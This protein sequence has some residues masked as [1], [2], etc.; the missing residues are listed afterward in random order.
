MIPSKLIIDVF[1]LIRGLSDKML[2]MGHNS[3]HWKS[4]WLFSMSGY[5]HAIKMFFRI[6][7]LLIS[8]LLPSISWRLKC[9]FAC[10]ISVHLM[11]ITG[12]IHWL[13]LEVPLSFFLCNNTLMKDPVYL[14]H[15][16]YHKYFFILSV[17]KWDVCW[18]ADLDGSQ[19][20]S[21]E[22]WFNTT[23]SPVITNVDQVQ[24]QNNYP[25]VLPRV[26]I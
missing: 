21:L 13:A 11:K 2:K 10:D 24:S 1:V 14:R 4:I 12:M 6:I 23:P 17:I 25:F 20:H 15:L 26:V 18:L 19:M 7:F 8:T 3:L 9:M 22:T 5:V 16:I